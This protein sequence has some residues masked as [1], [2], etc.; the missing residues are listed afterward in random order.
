MMTSNSNRQNRN[1]D[2]TIY[3][4]GYRHGLANFVTHDYPSLKGTCWD[5]ELLPSGD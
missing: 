4:T 3:E 1:I 5:D 2:D